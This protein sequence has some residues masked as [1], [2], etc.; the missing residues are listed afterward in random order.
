MVSQPQEVNFTGAGVRIAAHRWDPA[1]D[2]PRHGVALLLHGGGQTR[3][4]W[5]RTG[6]RLAEH[7]WVAVAPDCRGHGDTDW[8][9]DGDYSLH[10]MVD[11]LRAVT[12]A[13]G[14]RPVLVGA[15]MGGITALLAQGADP[16]FA[17]ALVLVDV[18]P[19]MEPD[20]TEEIAR[21]MLSGMDGFASL[22]EAAE[23]VV[24]YNPHRQRP[25]HPDGLRKNLRHRDGRWYWHWDPRFLTSHGLDDDRH[26]ML[27]ETLAQTARAAARSVDI[28]TLLVRG[29]QSRVVSPEGAREL[30]ELIPSAQR[31][32]VSDAGHMVAG[33]DNDVFCA[34][35]LDFLRTDVLR[36][37]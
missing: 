15:S 23:A 13:M 7:G 26:E 21:F 36:E 2:G 35:V 20:G 37:N 18:T 25:P 6:Q 5:Q 3:H 1:P 9:P 11:D 12:T 32:D 17:R 14:E 29:A 8:S 24:A 4:S 10:L 31:Y 28:P 16:L 30:R 22:E 33:D 34:G 19:T 27:T